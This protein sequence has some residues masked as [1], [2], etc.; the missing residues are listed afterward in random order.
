MLSLS[1]IITTLNEEKNIARC[2]RSVQG[3]ADEVIVVDS[4]S[5]DATRAICASFGAKVF[6]RAWEGYAAAK[7]FAASQA[8]H[9]FILSLDADEA[10]GDELRKSILAAKSRDCIGFFSFKRITNYCGQWIRHCGWY[11]DI[12]LRLYDRRLARWEKPIHEQL[13]PWPD[14]IQLLEG[15]CLHYSYYTIAG[16]VQQAN[17][18]TDLT[19]QQAFAEGRRSGWLKIVV[20]PWFKFFKSYILQLGFLDGYRGFVISRISAYAV[21]VK[22]AKLRELERESND[23]QSSTLRRAA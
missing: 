20:S 5:T 4:A 11:P 16:H 2:L 9:D 17:R 6:V 15:H 22:Y 10:L 18:F 8:A 19:A 21:F 7:N 13:A 14:R 12:K 23:S 1:V 3:V